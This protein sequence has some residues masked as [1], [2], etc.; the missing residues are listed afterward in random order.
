LHIEPPRA[1]PLTGFF[2]AI[3]ALAR[4]RFKPDETKTAEA[5]IERAANV[6]FEIVESG[7]QKA[8]N[9]VNVTA[10]K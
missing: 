2:A 9:A 8:M 4:S 1:Y 5:M 10:E 7:I 3:L 6:C